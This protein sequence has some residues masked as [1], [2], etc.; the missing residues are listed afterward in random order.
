MS[1]QKFLISNTQT[2][3]NSTNVRKVHLIFCLILIVYTLVDTQEQWFLCPA[4]IAVR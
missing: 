2:R 3:V 4:E 1:P